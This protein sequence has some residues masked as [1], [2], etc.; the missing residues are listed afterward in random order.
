MFGNRDKRLSGG[1]LEVAVCSECGDP[2]CGNPAVDFRIDADTVAWVHPHW[3]GHD[4]D[5]E[6]YLES[7][8]NDPTSLLP[9][10]LVFN[11]AEFDVALADAG[12][13]GSPPVAAEGYSINRNVVGSA[14]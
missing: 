11:R 10:V 9:P 8:A 13:T 4:E 6:V 2:G 14:A 1:E 12:A 3:A 5:D 7:D